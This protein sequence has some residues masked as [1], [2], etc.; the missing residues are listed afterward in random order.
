MDVIENAK[1][2]MH[3]TISVLKRD[4]NGLRAGR[5][6][7]QVLDRIMVDYYGTPTPINQMG[8]ISSPER[9]GDLAEERPRRLELELERRLLPP[10]AVLLGHNPRLEQL[11]AVALRPVGSRRRPLRS[12]PHL[13]AD[14]SGWNR[15]LRQRPWRGLAIWL[16]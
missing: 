10:P 14:R 15:L 8:N 5:A 13:R 3:K 4:L 16:R 11:D 2:K 9:P 7:A 1:D 12:R 6:N